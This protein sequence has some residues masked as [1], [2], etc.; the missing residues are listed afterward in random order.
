MAKDKVIKPGEWWIVRFRLLKSYEKITGY[1]S[2]KNSY[3]AGHSG[4]DRKWTWVRKDGQRKKRFRVRQWKVED[5]YTRR[6][7]YRFADLADA[8][9]Q[10][11]NQVAGMSKPGKNGRP[12]KWH[13]GFAEILRVEGCLH[14]HTVVSETTVERLFPVGINEMETLAIEFALGGE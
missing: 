11:K 6:L 14:Y 9:I 1:L 7:A 3:R 5:A 2:C 13:N 12:G 8:R 10:A 4:F